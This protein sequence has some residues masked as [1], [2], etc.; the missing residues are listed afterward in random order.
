MNLRAGIGVFQS[1]ALG[2]LLSASAIAALV[3]VPIGVFL[4]DDGADR[5]PARPTASPR[6]TSAQPPVVRR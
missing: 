6:P 3:A 4:F 5:A 2:V 1:S